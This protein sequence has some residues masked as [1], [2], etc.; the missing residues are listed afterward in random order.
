MT[1][2]EYVECHECG[3]IRPV[4]KMYKLELWS[5]PFDLQPY[6]AYVCKETPAKFKKSYRQYV[7]SCEEL[8]TDSSW[9][10]FRY[11]TCDHCNRMI[12]EQNPSN[13]WMSQV[14]Y[15]DDYNT[16]L[17]LKCYEEEL[18][19][20]GV[21]IESLEE[22]T[23]PGMFLDYN[24]LK[25]RDFTCV[26]D[27][28]HVTGKDSAKCVCD[29]GIELINSGHIVLIAYES[30]AIGGLEGYVSLYSKLKDDERE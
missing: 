11:F 27:D 14:R 6:I 4:S 16:T 28:I 15:L 21:E 2:Q 23:L 9:A 20:N 3:T 13:G 19:T 5:R 1:K 10:D 8:L 26:L 30:M 25:E 12:C 7:E 18:Y 29:K 22:G 24:E 17:C